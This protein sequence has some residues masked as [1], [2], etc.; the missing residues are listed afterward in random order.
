MDNIL[1][2]VLEEPELSGYVKVEKAYKFDSQYIL[3]I[4]TGEYGMS[5]PATTYVVGYDKK[6]HSVSGVKKLENCSENIEA[7]TDGNKLIVKKEDESATFYN[8]VVN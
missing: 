4:S 7:M 8:A 3:V 6:T 5:C 1:E 2:Q